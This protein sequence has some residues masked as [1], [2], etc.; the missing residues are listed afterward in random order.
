MLCGMSDIVDS[1]IEC[2]LIYPGRFGETAQLP[3]ELKRRCANF[4]LSSGWTEVMKCF[5]GSAHVGIIN[6]S[7]LTINYFVFADHA[8]ENGFV[9]STTNFLLA[10][11]SATQILTK[12]EKQ[13]LLGDANVLWLGE[14]TQG[15]FAT[16]AADAALFHAAKWNAQIAD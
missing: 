2:C 11:A 14:E 10:G 15:F 7:R 13:N 9:L 12:I 16:F 8:N 6:K 4:I 3:D 1:A 5:D